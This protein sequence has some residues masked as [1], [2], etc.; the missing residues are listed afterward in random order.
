MRR[1]TRPISIAV[2]VVRHGGQVLIGQRAPGAEL[3]G[4]WEFPGGKVHRGETPAQAAVRECVEEASLA[5]R[6][7]RLESVVTHRYDYGVVQIRFFAAE[8][9]DPQQKPAASFRWVPISE[10]PRYPFPSA[11]D[12]VLQHLKEGG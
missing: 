12:A 8:P 6:V 5:I 4:L 11:N 1:P 2:A 7:D 3:A 10:L 9:I